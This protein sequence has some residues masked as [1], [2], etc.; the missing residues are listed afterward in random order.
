MS[1]IER[2]S[3]ATV[4]HPAARSQRN[5]PNSCCNYSRA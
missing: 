3:P 2:K 5:S 1:R 4:T